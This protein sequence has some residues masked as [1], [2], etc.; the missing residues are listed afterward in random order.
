M[1]GIPGLENLSQADRDKIQSELQSMQVQESLQ[2]YNGLVERCFGECVS[3]FRAKTLDE[4]ET[5]CIKRCI[6]KYM[7]FSQR[8]GMRFAEKNQQMSLGK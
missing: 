7:Q 1:E 8:V 3:Q 2:T 6:S 5:D 4:V